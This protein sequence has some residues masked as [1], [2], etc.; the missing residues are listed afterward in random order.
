V[1]GQALDSAE[2]LEFVAAEVW[3]AAPDRAVTQP[4]GKG[5]SCADP[6]GAGANPREPAPRAPARS[7]PLAVASLSAGLEDADAF[8]LDRRLQ[9]AIRL[10][11]TLDAAMSPLLRV[12]RC[13]DYEWH[14]AWRPL[15][16]FAEDQLGMSG[17][18]A[19]ALL[20]LERAGDVCPELRDAYRRGRISWAK[21]QC[22]VPLLLLDLEG[23]WRAAWVEWATRVTMR[24]LGDDVE[25]ALLLR[26]GHHLAWQR[27]KFQPQNAQQPIPPEERQLCAHDVDVEATERIT[28]R[29]PRDVA[30][31]F[32]AAFAAA[33][34]FE[35]MLDHALEAWQSSGRRHPVIERDGYRCA[36]PGCTS[37]RNLHDHHVVFR[38]AGGSDDP[39]NRITLCAF[40]HLRGVHAGRMQ[41][42]GEAP[43]GLVFDLPLG[44]YLSGDVMS[45]R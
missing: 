7:L 5:A 45:P 22:L 24:R 44:R 9:R 29:V 18:K 16:S 40:H 6:S 27:C 2:V 11:Q 36:A 20:R 10:E 37:R 19:R 14:Q 13:V 4:C 26:A 17:R 41:V 21:A 23:D 15:A 1:A 34:S 3:S 42:R 28:L 39:R 33:G 38:S 31:L 30:M 35:A 12:V 43:D 8:E 32:A 25:R